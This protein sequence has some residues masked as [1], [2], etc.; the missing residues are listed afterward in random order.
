MTTFDSREKGFEDKFAHDAELQF[1]IRARR[2]KLVGLWAAEKMGLGG[3]AAKEYAFS[4]IDED[5]KVAGDSDVI[6]K[7]ASDTK[8]SEKEIEA[9]LATFE[10][11]ARKQ[12]LN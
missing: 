12:L 1:K 10:H 9:H 3:E 6:A 2:N 8:L 7:L 11:E 4:I 5:A